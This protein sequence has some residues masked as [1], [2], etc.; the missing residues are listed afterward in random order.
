MHSNHRHPIVSLADAFEK[1]PAKP[2]RRCSSNKVGYA[3]RWAAEDTLR[4]LDEKSKRVA[5]KFPVRIY[6]CPKC[7]AWHLTSKKFVSL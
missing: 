5:A 3:S 4:Y 1:A 7:E 6:L 2:T